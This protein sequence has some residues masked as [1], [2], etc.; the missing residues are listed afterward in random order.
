VFLSAASTVAALLV[1]DVPLDSGAGSAGAD[2]FAPVGSRAC[3]A[4]FSA[5]ARAQIAR[6][7]ATLTWNA[8]PGEA[9]ITTSLRS[10]VLAA[11]SYFNDTTAVATARAIFAGGVAGIPPDLASVVLNT[12][13]RYGG[14]SDALTM[15]NLY[16][17]ALAAGDST[18]ARRY[19]V[20]TTVSR[21]RN[22]L[23]TALA[24]VLGEL[25][26]VGDK[27]SLLANIA[28]NPWGRD[29]AWAWLT[30]QELGSYVNWVGLTQ[31]FPPGGFDMSSIVSALAGN[32]QTQAC[33]SAVEAFWGQGS[34]QRPG[35]VGAANDFVAAQEVVAR[36]ISFKGAQYAATCTYLATFPAAEQ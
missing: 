3:F 14:E 20:A 21:D 6:A 18:G 35:M 4:S 10:A 24:F 22:W 30:T 23:T 27:V 29:L 28:S 8:T 34:A 1:P 25:V 36:A 15:F 11:A 33:A 9:P 32:F 13:V 2:P 12:I 31:L 16:Q 5:Y 7:Q 17:D 19:L 26:P